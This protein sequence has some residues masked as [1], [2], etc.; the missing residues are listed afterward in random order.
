MDILR[1]FTALHRHC[2]TPEHGTQN[3][4][5]A[6]RP[7]RNHWRRDEPMIGAVSRL[8]DECSH[9]EVA[10]EALWVEGKGKR[11][12]KDN[13][14][15]DGEGWRRMERMERMEMAEECEIEEAEE[16]RKS[17]IGCMK[18]VIVYCASGET[19]KKEAPEPHITDITEGAKVT[20]S[21]PVSK[22]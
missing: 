3:I 13:L 7:N 20:K 17:V 2:A 4:A 6:T 14:K 9:Q 8:E 18:Q 12:E 11:K 5:R 15:H 1:C 21:V 10:D 22:H 16:E 19:E